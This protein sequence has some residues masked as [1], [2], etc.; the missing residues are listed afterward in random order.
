MDGRELFG[1]AADRTFLPLFHW[2][3]HYGFRVGVIGVAVQFF[4]RSAVL[5]GH[6][7]ID[8]RSAIVGG[9]PATVAADIDLCVGDGI[10]VMVDPA[11]GPQTLH[12]YV[13]EPL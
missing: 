3:I 12:W 6:V 5:M 8:T 2:D 4:R 11:V 1:Y 7:G 10:L 9:R 13:M